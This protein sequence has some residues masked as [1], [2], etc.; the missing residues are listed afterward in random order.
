[1]AR[2]TIL[3]CDNCGK[4]VDEA[5]G[6]VMRITYSDARRGAKQAD[7]CGDCAGSMPGQPAATARPPAEVGARHPRSS[8]SL[9]V[10]PGR[11]GDVRAPLYDGAVPLS[12][13]AGPA[14]AG[15]VELLLDRYLDAL[16]REPVLIVPNRSDVEY[17]AREL[18]AR[19]PALL[20]GSI[21]TFDDVFER[22]AFAG[23]DARPVVSKAQRAL[24]VRRV[25]AG[26]PL[27]GLAASAR[28]GGFADELLRTL[29]ELESGL[30]DPDELDGRPRRALRGLSRGARPA[31]PLGP[32]PAPPQ[33]GR[34][35]AVRP[36][37][38]ARRARLRV[39][40][41]G[42]HRRASGRCSR[43]SPR[44]PT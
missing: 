13:I 16:D 17:V 12:L 8:R 2:R 14:N 3:V 34:A 26:A 24:L 7:L 1:M 10:P 18:I 22:I 19:R 11:S 37:R 4:E 40:L 5:Q 30:L 21:D 32:R 39:R 15:K 29:G 33:R 25:L 41:R 31:R 36:R 27:D 20:G 6:A 9:R 43:R 42:P 38:V 23:G 35:A 28:F 44:A